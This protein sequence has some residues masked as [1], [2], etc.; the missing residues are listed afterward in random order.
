LKEAVRG[1]LNDYLP[2]FG[3]LTEKA[4]RTLFLQLVQ[5]LSNASKSKPAI[6][7]PNL[8]ATSILLDENGQLYICGWSE[9]TTKD[10]KTLL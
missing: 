8:Q 2:R 7:H 10:E 5:G 9:L 3:K 1:D 4:A 6:L